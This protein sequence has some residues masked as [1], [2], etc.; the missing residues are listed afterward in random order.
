MTKLNEIVKE[1][2]IQVPQTRDNNK[3]LFWYV[4][5]AEGLTFR[6]NDGINFIT[7]GNFMKTSSVDRILYYKRKN[8]KEN[9]QLKPMEYHLKINSLK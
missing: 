2:L 3:M 5:N 1:I 9:D 6:T 4:W 7:I 8:Q